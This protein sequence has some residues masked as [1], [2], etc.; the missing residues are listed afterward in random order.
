MTKII[1]EPGS[2]DDF[3]GTQS[4]LDTFVAKIT[5]LLSS[6]GFLSKLN[7]DNIEI[8]DDDEAEEIIEIFNKSPKTIN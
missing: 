1:F 2:F 5:E 3:E 4:E 8:I 6:D 7:D